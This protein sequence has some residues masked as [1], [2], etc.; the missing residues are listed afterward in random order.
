[1]VVVAAGHLSW[2]GGGGGGGR[3]GGAR[4][5]DK[6]GCPAATKLRTLTRRGEVGVE[7]EREILKRTSE[8]ILFVSERNQRV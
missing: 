7:R 4:A 8:Q 5:F 1:M 3:G 2:A 6:K